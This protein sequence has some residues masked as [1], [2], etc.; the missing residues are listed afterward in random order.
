MYVPFTDAPLGCS[1]DAHEWIA[2]MNDHGDYY[3]V[4]RGCGK[5]TAWTPLWPSTAL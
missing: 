5:Q 1:L 3:E 4:C 2:T